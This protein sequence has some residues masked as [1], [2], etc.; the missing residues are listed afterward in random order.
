MTLI[1]PRFLCIGFGDGVIVVLVLRVAQLSRILATT[2]FPLP[3]ENPIQRRLPN[4]DPLLQCDRGRPHCLAC[5]L[6]DLC[7]IRLH[8]H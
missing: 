8:R 1:I 7:L 6:M 2:D 3:V 4:A 5:K